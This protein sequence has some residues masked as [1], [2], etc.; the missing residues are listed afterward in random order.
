MKK[1]FILLCLCFP[2]F[3]L[4]TPSF[5]NKQVKI[6]RNLDINPNYL[7]NYKFLEHI[8]SLE[9]MHSGAL[10]R[11]LKESYYITPIIREQLL[12][13]KMPPELLYLAVVESGL[14]SHSVSN[15][16]AV[17]I[18]QF[19][20]P[21]ARSLGLKVNAYVDE[22]RDY[23]KSTTA[24]LDYLSR[25]KSEFGKWYLAILAYNC[26]DARLRRAIKQAKSNKLSVL[27]NPKKKYLPLETRL[28][29][30]KILTMAFLAN[31]ENFLLSKNKA[32][33]NYSLSS[34]LSSVKVPGS[35]SLRQLAKLAKMPYSKFHSL[36]PH[37]RYSFTPPVKSYHIYL[38]KSKLAGFN[39]AMLNA[40]IKR[41]STRIPYSRIYVVK[42]GDSLYNIAR[43]YK[44]KIASIKSFNKLKGSFLRIGQKLIITQN[45]HKRKT[46]VRKNRYAA[47]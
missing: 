23:V 26:G 20:R 3:A 34:Q 15:V 10:I 41:V 30:K 18:W 7:A 17:G 38:P 6:L 28:F 8:D 19:M 39:K 5:Y 35:A 4:Y 11:S 31:D 46:H 29:I 27:L 42:K 33:I 25:L 21:T 32:L 22:R 16:R 44:V 47:N 2:L 40:K 1:L 37:F 45:I 13:K 14:R 43:K 12:S 9:D 24:A 36:N